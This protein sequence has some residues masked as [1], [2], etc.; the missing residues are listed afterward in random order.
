MSESKW[1]N[2]NVWVL[3]GGKRYPKGHEMH[4]S[5]MDKNLT[6]AKEQMNEFGVARKKNLISACAR[7]VPEASRDDVLI[8][9]AGV[10]RACKKNGANFFKVY[11]TGH[12]YKGSGDW[13]LKDNTR[14]GLDDVIKVIRKEWG[15]S[16]FYIHSQC[17][18]AGN[19]AE[20]LAKY[21]DDLTS[22]RV[23]ASALPNSSSWGSANG[24]HF[25][26]YY[27]GIGPKP[28]GEGCWGTLYNGKHE[29]EEW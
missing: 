20:D 5:Q 27:F 6:I 10:A 13:D 3:F 21:K 23:Y 7:C 26:R 28:N 11:Y 1:A 17:C 25:T 29:Y 4:L 18:S 8:G 12:G 2:V 22:V 16:R 9:L 24:S 14:V 15:D 19:W